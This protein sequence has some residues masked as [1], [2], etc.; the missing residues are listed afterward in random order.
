MRGSGPKTVVLAEMPQM[1]VETASSLQRHQMTMSGVRC[2]LRTFCCRLEKCSFWNIITIKAAWGLC[3]YLTVS[4][5]LQDIR[6]P[7]GLGHLGHAFIFY[8]IGIGLALTAF[9]A[10]IVCNAASRCCSRRGSKKSDRI[11]HE[12]SD[13]SPP[14]EIVRTTIPAADQTN[15]TPNDV[16][17]PWKLE[18]PIGQRMKAERRAHYCNTVFEISKKLTTYPKRSSYI[19]GTCMREQL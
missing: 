5:S 19:C 4:Y 14:A 7:L 15:S 8:G 10:E 16:T 3:V 9:A 12:L 2:E 11:L 18:K 17:M 13:L 1:V 6:T